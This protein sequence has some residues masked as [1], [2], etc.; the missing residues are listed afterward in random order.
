[1]TTQ[2]GSNAAALPENFYRYYLTF[3]GQIKF[4]YF[5]ACLSTFGITK[6]RL[7]RIQKNLT[8]TGMAPLDRRGKRQNRP[9]AYER[10]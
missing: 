3:H 5:K 8:P 2:Q 7:E 9:K 6:S 10:Y 4:N 1:M